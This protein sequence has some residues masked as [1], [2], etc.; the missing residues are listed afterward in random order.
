[1]SDFSGEASKESGLPDKFHEYQ[2]QLLQKTCQISNHSPKYLFIGTNLPLFYDIRYYR[3]YKYPD[4]FLVVGMYPMKQPSDERVNY[5]TWEE[6][7]SPF[8]VIELLSPGSEADD[9]SQNLRHIHDPLTKWTVYERI[10]RVPYY[11]V[12]DHSENKLH[13]FGMVGAHY[14]PLEMSDGKLWFKDIELS[15]GVWQ[16][17]YQG[18]EGTWL[19][20]Y[21]LSGQLI[22]I[23]DEGIN[24]NEDG[25]IKQNN[26]YRN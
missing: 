20:W 12:F 26:G 6:G 23:A 24:R 7:V 4:W 2:P 5:V 25:Q 22:A 9:L 10:L 1:M 3:S 18:I 15:L 21:D 8:L 14:K 17:S 11:I 19:R 16:G 13:P